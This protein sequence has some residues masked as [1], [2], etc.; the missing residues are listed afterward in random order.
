MNVLVA[1]AS[2]HGATQEIAE[3]IGHA[4]EQASVTND[5]RR[6]SARHFVEARTEDLAARAVWLFS[7]GLLGD[8]PPCRST[9]PS[10]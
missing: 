9:R 10:L 8:P 6:V 3:A 1:S 4:L 7:S 2:K 5:V